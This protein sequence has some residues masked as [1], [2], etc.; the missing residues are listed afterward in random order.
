MIKREIP[1][2]TG[3]LVLPV[4][5]DKWKASQIFLIYSVSLEVAMMWFKGRKTTNVLESTKT[6]TEFSNSNANATSVT[7]ITD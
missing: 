2:A 3:M 5:S 1:I 7:F 6:L 4:S